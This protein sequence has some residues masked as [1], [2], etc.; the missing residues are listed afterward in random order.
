[1]DM[2]YVRERLSVMDS[3]VLHGT[4]Q[5]RQLIREIQKAIENSRLQVERKKRWLPTGGDSFCVLRKASNEN[6]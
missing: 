4:R 5:R 6:T 1:M 3:F 2:S